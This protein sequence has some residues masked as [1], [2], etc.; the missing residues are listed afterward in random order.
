MKSANDDKAQAKSKSKKA[1]NYPSPVI[2]GDAPTP[3][4]MQQMGGVVMDRVPV[5]PHSRTVMAVFRAKNEC[6]LDCYLSQK[7]IN[8]EQHAAGIRFRA[9]W[10]EAVEGKKTVDSLKKVTGARGDAELFLTKNPLARRTLNT[11]YQILNQSEIKVLMHVAGTDGHA[12]DRR[13]MNYLRRALSRL[14][15]YW[16]RWPS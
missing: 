16:H 13:R 10:L 15:D 14:A 11:A 7:K 2:F 6:T 9:A 4:R 8:H 1:K 3:E 5:H 12:G